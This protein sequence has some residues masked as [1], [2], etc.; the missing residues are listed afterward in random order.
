MK[1]PLAPP[2]SDRNSDEFKLRL[3]RHAVIAL[4][5]QNGGTLKIEHFMDHASDVDRG[6]KGTLMHRATPGGGWEFKYVS[7][8][9]IGRA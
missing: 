4:C 3:Y 5:K 2:V 9:E 6:E 1:K 8:Q 7:D